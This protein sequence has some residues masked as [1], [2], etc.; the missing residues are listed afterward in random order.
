MN[1]RN[2]RLYIILG[3]L[4]V[5]VVFISVAFAALSTTFTMNFGTASKGS[6]TWNVHFAPLNVATTSNVS[7]YFRGGTSTNGC[8]CS[9][10]TFDNNTASIGAITLSKP[11]DYCYWYFHIQNTGTIDSILSSFSWVAPTGAPSSCT[12]SGATMTCSDIVF[13]VYKCEYTYSGTYITCLSDPAPVLLTNN[14]M[15][16]NSNSSGLIK[17]VAEYNSSGVNTNNYTLSGAKLQFTL[18]QN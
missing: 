9:N 6:H 5:L 12:I 1:Y 3:V 7:P 16:I 4:C 11:G 8:S 14:S 15:T 2:R 10:A 17:V 13:R 18:S